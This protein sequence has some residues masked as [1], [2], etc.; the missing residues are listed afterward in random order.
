MYHL[1]TMVVDQRLTDLDRKLNTRQQILQATSDRLSL[2]ERLRQRIA[3]IL[4]SIGQRIEPDACA[5]EP[6][7]NA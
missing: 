2:T 1:N 3:A 5:T 4:I 7:F 6:Q